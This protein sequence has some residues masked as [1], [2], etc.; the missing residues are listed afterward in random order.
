VR[1]F[2]LLLVFI[3]LF[4]APALA[5]RVNV[6]AYVEGGEVVVECSYSKS[7]RVRHGAIAVQDAASG[8][9]LL[10]GTTDEE[11]LFRFSIP[12]QARTSGS[13]LRIL[14][15]AG[16]GHQNEWIVEATEFMDAAAPKPLAPDTGEAAATVAEGSPGG[17]GSGATVLS[18]TDVEEVVSA[19]LDAKLAPIKRELLEQGQS[20]P[21]MQ[22]IIGGIG[23]IFGL[24]GIAAYFKSRP[25]V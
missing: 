7:K 25:R 15:Q 11:G 16:E 4:S 2:F 23:W 20:G 19:V 14:L 22:E 9:T 13:G 18:R 1:S 3:F 8:E 17:A 21:G 5:H 12:D 6:F 10:Q 24:V